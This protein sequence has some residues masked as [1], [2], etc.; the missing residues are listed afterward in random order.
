MTTLRGVRRHPFI[1]LW[2]TVVWVLL[3]GELSVAN[4]L[5]GLVVALVVGFTLRMP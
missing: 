5:A 3:W 2:L 4:V 1:L